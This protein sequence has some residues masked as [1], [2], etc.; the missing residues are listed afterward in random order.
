MNMKFE[1]AVLVGQEDKELN[2]NRAKSGGGG[3][4]RTTAPGDIFF[5]RGTQDFKLGRN[6][7]MEIYRNQLRFQDIKL[8]KIRQRIEQKGIKHIKKSREQLREQIKQ[9]K[10]ELVNVN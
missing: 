3:Q 6:K 5:L 1:D 9:K 2:D 7:S 8:A 4:S 10:I